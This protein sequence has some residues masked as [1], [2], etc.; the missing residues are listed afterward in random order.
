LKEKGMIIMKLAII[1][2]GGVRSIFLAKSIVSKA[3]KLGIKEVVLMDSNSEKLKVFGTLAKKAVEVM[4]PNI[5]LKITTDPIEALKDADVIITAIRVGDDE[6][7]IHD[8][9]IALKYGVTGQE[10]TGAGGLAM[11]MRSI[12]AILEYCKLSKQYSKPDVLIFNFTNPSGLVTQALRSE[13]FNNVYG[14]CDFASSFIKQIANIR[15]EKPENISVEC[16]GL[17]HLSY[18]KSVKVNG[19]ER[20]QEIIDNPL[21]YEKTEERLFEPELVKS[22][23]MLLNGYLYFYYYREKAIENI[24][25]NSNTRGETV[26]EINKKM[27]EELKTIDIEKDFEKALGTYFKYIEMREKSYMSIESSSENEENKALSLNLNNLDEEGYA[28]VALRFIQARVENKPVEMVLSLPNEGSIK[29]LEDDDVV[30]ITCIIDKEGAKPIYIGEVPEIQMALIKQVKLYERLAVKAIKEK[31]RETAVLA[32]T[33]HPL[34]NSYSIA[35]K[36]VDEYLEVHKAYIGD[37]R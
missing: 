19:E 27:F 3:E 11:A 26:R 24:S 23:G 1:G 33:V 22:L 34:V 35:S 25:H 14:I 36:I 30:E 5:D 16:F 13:G 12:P 6:G 17:N 8:E 21:L 9:R 20:I 31:S 4:A 2:G 10:T 32:L 15:N 18:F 37:W 7:R 29:G 28:G